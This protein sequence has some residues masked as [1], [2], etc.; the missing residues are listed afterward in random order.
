MRRCACSPT[1]VSPCTPS[2]AFSQPLAQLL[3]SHLSVLRPG[4]EVLAY[5]SA[6]LISAL[7]QAGRRDVLV[8][9]DFRRYSESA[10]TL[11]RHVAERGGWIML[12]TDRWLSPVATHAESVLV[13]RTESVSPFD[14]LTAATALTEALVAGVSALLEPDGRARADA[15]ASLNDAVARESCQE[16]TETL[17]GEADG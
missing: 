12:I 4:V 3:A 1:P 9:Y 13:T 14:S 5:G 6:E 17:D 11:A 2:G 8:V 15:I 10:L 16:S 7:A